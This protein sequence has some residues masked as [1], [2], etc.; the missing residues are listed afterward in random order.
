MSITDKSQVVLRL[1]C[2]PEAFGLTVSIPPAEGNKPLSIMMDT[3]FEAMVKPDNFCF[4]TGTSKL[5][6]KGHH[7]GYQV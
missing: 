7:D 2:N 6:L 5:A 4:C 1:A 3:K